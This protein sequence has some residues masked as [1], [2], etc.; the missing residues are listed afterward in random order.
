MKMIVKN[1]KGF[2]DFTLEANG[3][4]LMVF[5]DN[6]T[7]KTSIADAVNWLFFNKDTQ[8]KTDFGIKTMNNGV[9]IPAISHEVEGVFLIDGNEVSLKKEYVEKYT[10]KR[11]GVTS[12]FTGHET[13][14]FIDGVPKSKGEYEKYI[15]SIVNED[16]FRLLTNP[17]YFNEQLHWKDKRKTLLDICGDISDED[18]I[19]SDK[20]LTTL[21]SILKGRTLDDHKKVIAARRKAINEELEKI[22]ASY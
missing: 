2:K 19:T 3:D 9:V 20:S 8:N 16:V 12:E 21:P 18:V 6:G 22:P 11:G 5:G 13:N 1:F 10:K 14:H 15:A 17:A 4:S 7:G